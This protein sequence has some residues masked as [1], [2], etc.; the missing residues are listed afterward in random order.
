MNTIW[1]LT[2]DDYYNI[3]ERAHNAGIKAG[4]SLD[5]Y[6]NDY[7]KEK[8]LKPLGITELTQEELLKSEAEKGK[9]VLSIKTD[10]KGNRN[11]KVIKGRK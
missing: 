6:I 3:L 4:E 1:A 10:K 2:I 9:N 7:A 5:K 8:G 11:Y